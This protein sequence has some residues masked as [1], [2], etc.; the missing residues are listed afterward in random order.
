MSSP[1]KVITE[2]VSSQCRVLTESVSSQCRVITESVSS[3][4]RVI[5]ESV[6]SQCRV[7]TESVSSQ[8]RVITEAVSSRCRVITEAVSSQCRV[9]RMRIRDK[10]SNFAEW[11]RTTGPGLSEQGLATVPLASSP[12]GPGYSEH[13]P[14]VC[15]CGNLP[16]HWPHRHVCSC[17]RER[18]ALLQFDV[19]LSST[20]TQHT[21]L[22][23]ATPPSS[24]GFLW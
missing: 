18:T 5:T 23:V 10:F 14:C 11:S 16:S 12:I 15:V 8:C 24:S 3:H 2:S 21:R 4:C 7:I 22:T 19:L 17:T 1:C 13:Y 9:I 20:A 6:S